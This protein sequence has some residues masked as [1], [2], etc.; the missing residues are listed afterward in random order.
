[1]AVSGV[2]TPPPS[3]PRRRHRSRLGWFLLLISLVLFGLAGFHLVRLIS[4]G[5]DYACTNGDGCNYNRP[6]ISGDVS[7]VSTTVTFAIITLAVAIV[8]FTFHRIRSAFQGVGT[9]GQTMFGSGGSWS[10]FGALPLIARTLSAALA[11][12]MGAMNVMSSGTSWPGVTWPGMPGGAIPGL[13]GVTFPGMAGAPAAAA[14][15]GGMPAAWPGMTG[16]GDPAAAGAQPGG[17]AGGSD[18]IA[19]TDPARAATIQA[20]GLD[21][22]AV[23]AGMHDV[24]MVSGTKRMYE[25]D[26][27]V[28]LPGTATY[29]VKHMTWVPV[30]SVGRLYAGGRLPAKID[31][32][33]HNSLVLELSAPAG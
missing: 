14:P 3:Q 19:S 11:S 29:H 31:P 18:A 24:G 32:A 25:L 4:R 33:D 1:V 21:G 13:P 26:L 15:P 12:R 28:T 6:D 7:W 5:Y 23:I 9:L 8:V 16:G 27:A 17:D 2:A 10:G 22:E 30:A 20:T